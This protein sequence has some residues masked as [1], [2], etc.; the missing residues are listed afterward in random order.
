MILVAPLPLGCRLYCIVDV[1]IVVVGA[2]PLGVLCCRL[3]S[4]GKEIEHW[5]LQGVDVVFFVSLGF[6]GSWG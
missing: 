6:L 5:R 2:V 3:A 1:Q 4:L